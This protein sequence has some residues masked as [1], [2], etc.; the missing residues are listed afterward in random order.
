MLGLPPWVSFAAVIAAALIARLLPRRER[1]ARF[2][3]QAGESRWAPLAAGLATLLVTLWAW[4]SLR[5]SPVM[6]DESAYLL[7]AELFARLRWT[8]E[9]RPIAAFFEQLYVLMDPALASKYPPGNSL[10]LAPGA[11][12]GLPGLPVVL[13]NGLTGALTFALARRIGGP[14]V[15]LLCWTFWITAFPLIYYHANYMSEGV[16]SVAWL[17]AWWGILEWIDARRRGHSVTAARWL[18]LGAGAVA[19]CA[20][21]R[22]LT[23]VALGC[24]AGAVVLRQATTNRWWRDLRLAAAVAGAIVAILPLWS[25]RTTGSATVSPLTAYTREY[26]PFD[27]P[28]FGA[29]IDDRPSARLPNDQLITSTAFYQ[30]HARH[31]LRALPRI[32]LERL[33]MLDRDAW[34]DW[35]G[36]LRVFALIALF[37]LPA[38]GWIAIAAFVVQ[39]ALYLS[40]AHPA[41]WTIYYVEVAAVPA[42]L[43]AIGIVR[44][45][46]W[47]ERRDLANQRSRVALATGLLMVAA[48]VPGWRIA[49]QVKE[50]V[51]A[52][53]AYYDAFAVLLRKIPERESL[54]FVRYAKGHIDG[55]SLVRNVPDPD[56]APIWTAYDRGDDNQRLIRLVPGRTAYLF[57]EASWSLSR[58]QQASSAARSPGVATR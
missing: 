8:G 21:T 2:V 40:Y 35:R 58:V 47:I 42:L 38:A 54:V 49:A 36:G 57:D 56:A 31:T 11:L 27:K 12:L 3:E 45:L 52:D 13:M 30:E 39:F 22:P 15:A 5:R 44:A 55:L 32:V 37:T 19:W 28:G 43:T 4:G 9:P 7:Q 14:L 17:V 20:I 33:K 53:H 51:S 16:T 34:V 25:W 48:A 23:G 18:A 6:H 50:K 24:V 26:V 41:W 10:L 1:A 29:R 46:S